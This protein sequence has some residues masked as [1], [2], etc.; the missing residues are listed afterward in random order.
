M[1]MTP[2]MKEKFKQKMAQQMQ[3]NSV[4]AERKEK[5]K[6][7]ELEKMFAKVEPAKVGDNQ[8][9]FSELF[10]EPGDIGPDF[11]VNTYH[12]MHDEWPE[13]VRT[14]VPERDP[15]YQWNKEVVYAFVVGD[16][17]HT[18]LVGLPGSGK[19]SL[20]L[21]VAAV[22]GRPVFKQAFQNDLEADEWIMSKEIDDTGTHWNVLPF[23]KALE[24]P[25][26]SILDEFNRLRRGGRL[27][28][29]QLLN[30][31]GS[32]Q[33]RDGREVTPH[34]EWRAVATDNTRGMGDGL[35]K[36]DGDIADISTTDRFGMMLEVNYLPR[37][38]QV[39]LIQAWF[40]EIDKSLAE[41]IVLFG[42]KII[43]GYKAGAFPLP[44][45]PRRMKKAAKIAIRYRNPRKGLQDA[46]YNFLA[47]DDERKACNQALKD[48]G[49]SAKFG[50][51][52]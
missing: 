47:E 36:F 37:E 19:T 49:I 8:K 31:G 24:Y 50:D 52:S 4:K 48:V 1:A 26:Y 15:T 39:G 45:T 29:N 43:T 41:D 17:E 2:E 10:F 6:E 32:L 22:T 38:Q 3:Q 46:Y 12:H 7:V 11:P 5:E 25:M 30:E 16:D 20:P 13:W 9:M 34:P 42:E 44:W 40:P 51:F 27:L 18:F 14:L 21:Q 23:V 28:M 35:D 33:L